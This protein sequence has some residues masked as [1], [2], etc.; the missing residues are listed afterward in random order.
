MVQNEVSGAQRKIGCKPHPKRGKHPQKRIENVAEKQ[1]AALKFADYSKNLFLCSVLSILCKKN[2][3]DTYISKSVFSNIILVQKI[4]SFQSQ[5][6]IID[7]KTLTSFV[8]T[9][10]HRRESISIKAWAVYYYLIGGC[11]AIPLYR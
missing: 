2:W 10:P 6:R 9:L 8:Y 4:A 1:K 5:S 7:N 11:L 3:K